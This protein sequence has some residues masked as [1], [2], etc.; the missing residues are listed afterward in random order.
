MKQ[1]YD[2]IV[3]GGGTAGAVA[4][5]Q[6]VRAGHPP[7]ILLASGAR[8]C[9]KTVSFANVWAGSTIPRY[10]LGPPGD[11][12]HQVG[13]ILLEP[14]AETERRC[15]QALKRGM[16][17]DAAIFA[18]LADRAALAAGADVLFHALPPCK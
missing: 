5:I 3:A 12:R 16:R 17:M 4:A 6:A 11:R 8:G 7:I 10:C 15:A 2:V 9:Y 14:C 13:T 18:A 1:A